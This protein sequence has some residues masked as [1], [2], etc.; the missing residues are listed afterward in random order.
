V[1]DLQMKFPDIFKQKLNDA[2]CQYLMR[3]IDAD[4]TVGETRRLY[5]ARSSALAG[6]WASAQYKMFL[7]KEKTAEIRKQIGDIDPIYKD[8]IAREKLNLTE[9]YD[10][11]ILNREKLDRQ[12]RQANRKRDAMWQEREYGY[13]VRFPQTINDFCREAVYMS[14]CLIGYIGALVNNDTTILFIRQPDDFNKPFITMEVYQ[15]ELMQAYHR[16]N[17][18]CTEEEADWIR[19]Y[20]YRHGIGCTR[21]KFNVAE[22]IL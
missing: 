16:F 6:M 14:N 13:V 18:D 7:H 12:I 21:F 10:Y 1:K 4:L 22:D 5:N 9:M 15:G 19:A 3:L 2:Q 11:L 8:A 20:C 17:M